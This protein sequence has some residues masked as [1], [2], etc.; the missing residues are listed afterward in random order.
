M[1][2]ADVGIGDG[3]I[4]YPACG[5]LLAPPL[6]HIQALAVFRRNA[7]AFRA[8]GIDFVLRSFD[9]KSAH[10][11]S[12]KPFDIESPNVTQIFM[13]TLSIATPHMTSLSTSGRKL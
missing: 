1:I 2:S 3:P 7:F 10:R 11:I 4:P 12:R 13:P 9:T 5:F 6:T 8:I